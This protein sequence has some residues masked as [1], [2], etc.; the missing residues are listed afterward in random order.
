[1]AEFPPKDLP[2]SELWLS[3][4]GR[5]AVGVGMGAEG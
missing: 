1:M 3:S 5:F 2:N 4:Q